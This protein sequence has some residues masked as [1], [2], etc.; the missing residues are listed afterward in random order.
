MTDRT[1]RPTG[2]K[3][4]YQCPGCWS[5]GIWPNPADGEW[6]CESCGERLT[7]VDLREA[8]AH[9]PATVPDPTVISELDMRDHMERTGDHECWRYMTAPPATVPDEGRPGD[10]YEWLH[11]NGFSWDDVNAVAAIL[12]QGGY[13]IVR[14]ALS[15][16]KT[17]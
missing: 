13:D 7:C 9:P 2:G 16:P 14:A 15:N 8:A 17:E 6:E 5:Y 1:A 12:D 4:L 3:R 11:T 10:P